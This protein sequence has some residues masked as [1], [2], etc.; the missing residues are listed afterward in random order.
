MK[1]S[2]VQTISRKDYMSLENL[3]GPIAGAEN[4]LQRRVEIRGGKEV[5]IGFDDN[6]PGKDQKFYRLEENQE[7]VTIDGQTFIRTSEDIDSFIAKQR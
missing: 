1:I 3:G 5:T 4:M 6:R 2:L 7:L